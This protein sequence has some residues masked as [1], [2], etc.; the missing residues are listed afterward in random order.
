MTL[1]GFKQYFIL[2]KNLNT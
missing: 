2:L 1:T